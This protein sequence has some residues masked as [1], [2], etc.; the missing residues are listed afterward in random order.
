MKPFVSPLVLTVLLLPAIPASAEDVANDKG[1]SCRAV[2]GEL[3]MGGELE[4]TTDPQ[5]QGIPQ[6]FVA[7]V[8]GTATLVQT[9]QKRSVIA[10]IS[11]A[12]SE[13]DGASS[14]PGGKG[15]KLHEERPGGG[16]DV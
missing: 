1:F 15:Y 9:E 6:D 10:V 16:K 7:A 11:L 13:N 12:G 14:F 2:D 8:R 3:T 4:V 5:I